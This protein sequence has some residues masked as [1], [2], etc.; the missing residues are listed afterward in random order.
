MRI[1]LILCGLALLVA[2]FQPIWKIDLIAP[3]YP[4]GLAL[5]IYANKL[6]GNVE[7]I[8]GLNHYIGMRELHNEDFFEFKILPYIIMFFSLLFVIVGLIGKRGWMRFLLIF[9]LLF[10]I[11]AMYDFWRWE[12]DYGHNLD[13]NAAIQI[14]GM[15]YQPPLI[16]FKQLLNFSAWSFPDVGGW[17]FFGAGIVLLILVVIDWRANRKRLRTPSPAYLLLIGM[18]SLSSCSSGPQPIRWGK[19]NCH[20]CKMTISDQ[21]FGAEVMTKKSKAYLF[22]DTH[23]LFKFLEEGTVPRQ[24]IRAIY[25]TNFNAPNELLEVTQATLVQ[26]ERIKGPMNG[27][28]AA[29]ASEEAA[30]QTFSGAA[31][32]KWEALEQ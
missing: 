11:V 20:F 17:F 12:Y 3:Q 26:D 19:D 9:F 31:T 7:I 25:L 2:L 23:C 16:G 6:G 4:E 13:P 30:K 28:I 22:D 15:A 29:F 14:P 27:D 1:V 10:G 24:D 8:N 18:L 5:L 21:R 32:I